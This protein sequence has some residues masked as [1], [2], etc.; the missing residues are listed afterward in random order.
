MVAWRRVVRVGRWASR[1][2]GLGLGA[3]MG[4]AVICCCGNDGSLSSASL[5]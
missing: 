3:A 5:L 1:G 4:G 2:V